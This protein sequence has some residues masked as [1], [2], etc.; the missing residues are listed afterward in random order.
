MEGVGR[1]HN[2]HTKLAHQKLNRI[3]FQDS[4]SIVLKMHP[5]NAPCNL[6]FKRATLL[7]SM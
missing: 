3:L 2:V 7:M 1:I 5:T 4:Q 6:L